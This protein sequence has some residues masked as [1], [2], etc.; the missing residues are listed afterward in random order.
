MN[1]VSKYRLETEVIINASVSD[2]WR[3]LID[4]PNYKNWNSFIPKASGEPQLDSILKIVMQPLGEKS[5]NYKVKITELESEKRFSWLG[6]FIIP[7]LID[8]HHFFELVSLEENQTKL[9][10]SENF[11]GILIPFVWNSFIIPKLK[12]CFG[13]L[14]TELKEY[15]EKEK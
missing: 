13:A 14:N 2:V 1:S 15:L 3:V 8:G 4:F 11:R 10:Q 12:P 5:Q 9:I 6:H 7:G